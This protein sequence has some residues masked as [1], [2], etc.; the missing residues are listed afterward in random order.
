MLNQT[1]KTKHTNWSLSQ[2]K[3]SA[4]GWLCNPRMFAG[5]I[6]SALA[7][8]NKK[9]NKNKSAVMSALRENALSG[10][11]ARH[12]GH[13]FTVSLAIQLLCGECVKSEFNC[14]RTQVWRS[15]AISAWHTFHMAGRRARFR[16]RFRQRRRARASPPKVRVIYQ[17][18]QVGIRDA[19]GV[20]TR[21]RGTL[22]QR[23]PA[24]HR[25]KR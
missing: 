2:N 17:M 7:S 21:R 16:L 3:Y 4:N 15:D 24:P 13:D 5:S 9:W 14:L 22:A 19:V 25:Y 18:K 1:N 6:Y 23:Q 12:V 10:W 11:L 8:L 20:L